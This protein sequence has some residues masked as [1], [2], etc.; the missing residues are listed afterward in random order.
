MSAPELSEAMRD[1]GLEVST[2]KKLALG[3]VAIHVGLK[4]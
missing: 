1:A 4:P 3:T 2:Y